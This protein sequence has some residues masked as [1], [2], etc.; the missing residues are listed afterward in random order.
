L[1]APPGYAP[2]ALLVKGDAKTQ[3]ELPEDD[4]FKKSIEAFLRK[5]ENREL[6]SSGEDAIL[7]QARLVSEVLEFATS[8]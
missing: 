1:T 3:I 2:T 6:C 8:S 7:C 5:V 4:S